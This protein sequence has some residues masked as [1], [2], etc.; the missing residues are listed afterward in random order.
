MG[1]D[2]QVRIVRRQTL[3]MKTTVLFPI[4]IQIKCKGIDC[5]KPKAYNKI[6]GTRLED[7]SS[8][9]SLR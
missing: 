8:R 3:T 9:I 5:E 1:K 2:R 7:V 6:M 4:T